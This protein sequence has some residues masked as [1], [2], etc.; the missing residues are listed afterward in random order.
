[1][2]QG[3]DEREAAPLAPKRSVVGEARL[4]EAD[5]VATWSSLPEFRRRRWSVPY[6][7]TSS[8]VIVLS[9]L[10]GVMMLPDRMGWLFLVAAAALLLVAGTMW[11][12]PRERAKSSWARRAMKATGDEPVRFGFDEQGMSVESDA[13]EHRL[14]WAELTRWLELE[15]ALLVYAGPTLILVPKRAFAA[16]QV[17]LVRALL[18]T[19]ITR[20]P[21]T[22]PGS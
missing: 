14:P 1:M 12:L 22:E 19:R 4:T 7:L 5:F 8:G 20:R 6:V 2:T 21:P 10:A 18:A 17:E 9:G 3:A 13:S 15:H 11:W 16:D